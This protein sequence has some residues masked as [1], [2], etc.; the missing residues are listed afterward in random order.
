MTDWQSVLNDDPIPWLLEPDNPSAR[1][2]T[3]LD[4]LDRSAD[5]PEVRAARA[6]LPALPPVAELL[7]VQKRDGYWVKRDYYLPKHLWHLLGA[8]HLG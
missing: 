5:G 4:I 2:W 8:Q 3:L 7:A 6:A 1:Y